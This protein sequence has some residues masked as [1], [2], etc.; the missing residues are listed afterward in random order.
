MLFSVCGVMTKAVIWCVLTMR[1]G[2]VCRRRGVL[3]GRRIKYLQHVA[4]TR[5]QF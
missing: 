1:K 3:V 4:G 5:V 2:D